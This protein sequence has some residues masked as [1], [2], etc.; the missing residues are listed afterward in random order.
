MYDEQLFTGICALRREIDRVFNILKNN[1]LVEKH[2][3]LQQLKLSFNNA[4]V[5]HL[6]QEIHQAISAG[7][8]QPGL[9][10]RPI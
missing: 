4:F 9:A 10:A 8:R 5:S 6:C 2:T 7:K 1:V 3:Q